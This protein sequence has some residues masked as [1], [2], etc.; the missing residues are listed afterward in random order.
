MLLGERLRNLRDT[1]QTTLRQI[2]EK[3]GLPQSLLLRVE[4]GHAVPDMNQLERWA[5]A[6]EVPVYGL[7][8]DGENPPLLENLRN[9]LSADDIAHFRLMDR[10]NGI[11]DKLP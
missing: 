2:A 3:S 5:A 7:F 6:L 4:S 11:L 9:R 1:K 10:L 8:Y